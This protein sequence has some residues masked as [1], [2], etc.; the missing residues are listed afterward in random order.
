MIPVHAEAEKNIS[1]AMENK[2]VLI[3][4]WQFNAT[5]VL[6]KAAQV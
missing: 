5:C 1:T 4:R 2:I 3:S 6:E